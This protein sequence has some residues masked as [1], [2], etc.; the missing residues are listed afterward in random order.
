VTFLLCLTGLFTA[1]TLLVVWL[2]RRLE[3]KLRPLAL[4]AML[5]TALAISC[6]P[7][8]QIQSYQPDGPSYLEANGRRLLRIPAMAEA[9]DMRDVQIVLAGLVAGSTLLGGLITLK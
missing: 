7:Y 8:A 3:S 6:L 9:P 4:L 2:T 5:A 1:L